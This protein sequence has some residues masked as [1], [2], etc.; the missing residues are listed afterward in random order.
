V[1][2][3]PPFPIVT[4][5]LRLQPLTEA[6]LDEL[7][8]YHSMEAVHRYLPMGPLDGATAVEWLR[9]GPWSGSALEKP[10]DTVC[11]GVVLMETGALVGDVILMWRNERQRHGEIGYVFHPDHA[12]QGYATEAAHALLHLAFDDLGWHRVTANI[13]D[14]NTP[15]VG[16]AERLG[17]RHEARH[18]ESTPKDDEWVDLHLYALL[19][20]E[21]RDASSVASCPRCR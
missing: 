6:D 1:P 4:A 5:R 14:G 20:R 8:S 17:M 3:L 19:D 12:G 13:F 16:V 7:L 9:V 2:D 21:W 10:G 15:S 18:L 11:C